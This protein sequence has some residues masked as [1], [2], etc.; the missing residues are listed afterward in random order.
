M[1]YLGH[2]EFGIDHKPW[3]TPKYYFDKT[4]LNYWLEQWFLFYSNILK[5][6]ELDENCK[7]LINEDFSHSSFKENK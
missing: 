6:N 5:K 2:N 7:F 3:N 1:N 4:K